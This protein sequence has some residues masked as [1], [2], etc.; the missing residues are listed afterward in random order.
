MKSELLLLRRLFRVDAVPADP[1]AFRACDS[2][3]TQEEQWL[4]REAEW[5][6]ELARTRAESG[7]SRP[8]RAWLSALTATADA[9]GFFRASAEPNLSAASRLLGK[10]RSSALRAYRELQGRFSKEMKRILG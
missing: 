2:L 9:G 7:L 1:S 8:Q 4:E 3:Q 5:A 6:R 10:N